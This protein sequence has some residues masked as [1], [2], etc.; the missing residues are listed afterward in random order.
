MS[1]RAL[2]CGFL[3]A[4]MLATGAAWAQTP[5]EQPAEAPA[6]VAAPTIEESGLPT[7]GIDAKE[8]IGEPAGPPLEGELLLTTLEEITSVMRCPVCQ[9]L[10][11]A[12][13]P[14]ASAIA[15]REEVRS[16]LREG[17]TRDQIFDYFEGAYGEF[18][19][20]SPRARGFN[21]VVWIAPIVMVLLGLWLVWARTRPARAEATSEVL[22]DALTLY[23]ERVRREVGY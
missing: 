15:I 21:L 20:L 17:Y 12:D 5:A 8:L 19:R 4:M 2:F 9:G 3:A 22:D 6:A 10:S 18:I 13:S 23:R 14:V 16:L 7:P 11:V 1:Y